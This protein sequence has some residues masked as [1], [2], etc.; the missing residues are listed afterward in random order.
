[1]VRWGKTFVVQHVYSRAAPFARGCHHNIYNQTYCFRKACLTSMA[2]FSYGFP[3]TVPVMNG[4]FA[5]VQRP[6]CGWTMV[7]QLSVNRDT[8]TDN[9]CKLFRFYSLLRVVNNTP[10]NYLKQI[11]TKGNNSSPTPVAYVCGVQP[12]HFHPNEMGEDRIGWLPDIS[13]PSH[14]A[15]L[16]GT[17]V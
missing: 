5:M 13:Y 1:M 15:L 4:S 12:G 8:P 3:L 6:H 2:T 9:T 14:T 17:E 11:I 7:S 10:I 16:I